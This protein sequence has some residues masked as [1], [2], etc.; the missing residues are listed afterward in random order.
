MTG[1]NILNNTF[2]PTKQAPKHHFA[3]A[4]VSICD[5]KFYMTVFNS[6]L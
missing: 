3:V 5:E 6:D 2:A 4:K 1:L